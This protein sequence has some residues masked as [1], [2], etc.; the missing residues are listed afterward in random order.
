MNFVSRFFSRW[1]TA[2]SGAV[3]VI[4][5]LA[6]T[7]ALA[8][9]GAHGPNG[10]HL[11]APSQAGVR[12]GT[13]PR[14]EASSETFE[15]VGQLQAGVL[16]IL[17]NRFATNEP[18]LEATVE[19]ESGNVKAPARFHADVGHYV[20]DDLGLLQAL[21]APGDHAMVVTVLAGNESDLLDGTLTVASTTAHDNDHAQDTG[22]SRTVWTALALLIALAVGWFMGRRRKSA[23][24]PA[25]GGVL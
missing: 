15:L 24:H 19:V 11:D 23:G 10:E 7:P 20:M 5:V 17:I 21:A 2:W 14:F 12:G 9:P 4:L 13:V 3:L 8:A 16:S 25:R 1:R 6:G 18:V 22:L